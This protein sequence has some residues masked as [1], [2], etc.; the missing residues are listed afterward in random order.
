MALLDVGR[1]TLAR[2]LP[3]QFDE[4]E[5]TTAG[6]LAAPDRPL[7]V[8]G[9]LALWA[10]LGSGLYLL[11]VGAWLVPALS[12][13]QAVIAALIGA[14][15]GAALVAVAV[16]LGA[17]ENRPGVVLHRGVLGE[18]GAHLY[19]ALAC[20]RHLAWG[21]LQL[22]IA[23]ELAAAVMG[24]Q[25]LGGG[26]PLW[27]AIFGALV[28]LMV[29]AGPATVTRRWLVPSALLTLLIAVVFTY[30]AW[31]DFGVPTMLLR[32]ASGGWPS[33]TAAVDIVAAVALIWL[34]VATDLGRLG[35]PRRAGMAAFAGL[36]GMTA[37]FVLLGVLFI[38]AVNGRDLAGFLLATP[39]GAL[40]LLLVIV[41]ELD[42]AFVSLYGLASTARAWAPKADAALPAVVGGAAVFV[43]GAAF[44]DPFDY[45]DALLLL[46][47]AF[48]PLLGV[49]L[50]FR[51]VRHWWLRASAKTR[52]LPD[53]RVEIIAGSISPPAPGGAVAWALGFLLYNWAAPLEL[54]AW[55]A[56]MSALFHDFL[57]LPFP[58][59]VPGL[60]A[61]ALGFVVAFVVA[62]GTAGLWLRRSALREGS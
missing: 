41:L 58:A 29:L 34:P 31:S 4:L 23:A 35:K 3:L 21:A 61:T 16:R 26:R 50:G 11:V 57:G 56:A 18:S 53:G 9:H 44:I 20:F 27:A 5:R 37:W 6:A 19:G 24:R 54:P 7:G 39:A 46:G 12:I 22:A 42:G 1:E 33:M 17:A 15:L 8:R 62:V 45:G 51:A 10:N 2:R 14:G 40:A 38:P 59:D 36:A 55:T 47:A 60:S 32:E 30:S 49:L 48:A 28:L 25:G 43:L 13:P 52:L